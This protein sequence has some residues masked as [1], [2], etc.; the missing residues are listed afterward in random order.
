M[1]ENESGWGGLFS[2]ENRGSAVALSAGVALYAT[3]SYIVITILPSVVQ[4]IGGLAWYAWNMTL[5]VVSSILGS[6]LSARLMRKAGPRGSYLTATGIF[7]A[8]AALCAA[9]PSM[10][11]LLLGRAIQGLGGGF[12][13]A[14]SYAMINLVFKESLWPRAMALI[15]AM[16]GIATLIGPAI[17]GIFAE[18]HAWRYAFGLLVPVTLLFGVLVWRTLPAQQ[19]KPQAAEPLPFIQLALLTGSVLV[20]SAGSLSSHGWVNLGGIVV[21]LLMVMLLRQREFSSTVRLLP[22]NSL[23]LSSPLCWLYMTMALLMIGLGCEIYVPYMLQHLHGQTPLAAGY[24]TAAAA[25]GWTLSE[26]TSAGWT[27]RRANQAIVSGPVILAVGLLLMLI[28]IPVVFGPPWFNLSGIVLGLTLAGFGIGLGWPH[29]L[30]RVLQQA[31]EQEKETAGASITLVQSFAAALG[32]ELAGTIANLAGVN[33]GGADAASNAA[34]WLFLAFIIPSALG[35]FTAWRSV[36]KRRISHPERM[37]C[38]KG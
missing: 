14:L 1:S 18:L 11:I 20:V 8:G 30:T 5:F 37:A 15:S 21:A 9:A 19:A 33:G 26:M 28:S 2:A 35:I 10:Q 36:S 13:F 27:G 34:F 6:A 7:M 24:I 31:D 17:G 22:R 16:W 23:S 38:S 32:A 3:N 29:L 12:L 4:D 25:A